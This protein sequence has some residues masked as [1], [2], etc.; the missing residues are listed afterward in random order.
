M[1]YF[2][3][4]SERSK[5]YFSARR[6]FG[7][8]R[9]QGNFFCKKIKK[10]KRNFLWSGAKRSGT[11]ILPACGAERSK[12]GWIWF[13]FFKINKS[14]ITNAINNTPAYFY[15]IRWGFLYE[16]FLC[17]FFP[18]FFMFFLFFTIFP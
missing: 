4:V 2:L 6:I 5:M 15:S 3:Q 14:K 13:L 1:V 17:Y 10:P 7:F 11:K 16:F 9:D 8:F 12:R 18:D